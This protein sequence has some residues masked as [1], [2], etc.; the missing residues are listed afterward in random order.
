MTGVWNHSE[1]TGVRKSELL[2]VVSARS[3][4]N[5]FNVDPSMSRAS[6]LIKR[7]DKVLAGDESFG[8][9]PERFVDAVFS[10]LDQQLDAFQQKSKPK[11]VAEIYVERDRARIKQAVLNRVMDQQSD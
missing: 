5:D 8:D 3:L 10:E 9:E 7:L 4:H 6:R 1:R 2:V 11:L